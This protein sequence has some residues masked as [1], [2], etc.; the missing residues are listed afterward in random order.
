MT[1]NVLLLHNY[2][3]KMNGKNSSNTW[4][5]I[6]L[7]GHQIWPVLIEFMQMTDNEKDC[8]RIK[9]LIQSY[10]LNERPLKLTYYVK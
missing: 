5:T 3:I 6:T 9:K 2:C 8:I 1:S 10:L 4:R 7:S